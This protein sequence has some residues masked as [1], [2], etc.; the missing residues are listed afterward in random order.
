MKMPAVKK[1]KNSTKNSKG[2]SIP[3]LLIVLL[4]GAIILVLALPHLFLHAV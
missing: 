2:F 3:E 4:V 1:E